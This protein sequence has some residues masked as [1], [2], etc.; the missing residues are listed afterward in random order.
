MWEMLCTDEE[1]EKFL[2]M[3]IDAVLQEEILSAKEAYTIGFFDGVQLAKE[4][5]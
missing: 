1:K 5:K 3:L 2:D 4:V